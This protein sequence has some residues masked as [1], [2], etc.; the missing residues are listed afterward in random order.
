MTSYRRAI[1]Q[2]VKAAGLK[3]EDFEIHETGLE[4]NWMAVGLAG[5]RLTHENKKAV[6]AQNRKLGKVARALVAAGYRPT[7]Y[8]AGH[9]GHFIEVNECRH[10]GHTVDYSNPASVYHY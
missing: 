10:F 1:T 9:G 2:A 8:T 3:V 5:Q 6:K 7:I 4:P